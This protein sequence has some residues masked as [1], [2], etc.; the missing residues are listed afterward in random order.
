MEISKTRSDAWGEDLPEETR[1]EI[2]GFTKPPREGDDES[3]PHLKS[4]EDAREHA[5]ARGI[6]PPSR[7]G[8]YR[9]LARMRKAEHLRLVYRV[10]GAGETATDLAR[11]AGIS[12]ATAAE[13]FRALSVNAAMDGD[14]KGAALYANAAAK[15][16]EATLKSNEL[17]LRERAQATKDD[18]L[19]LAREKFEF[20]AA[21][22]AMA[23]AAEIKGIAADDGLDDDE[24]IQKVR[25]A[26]FGQ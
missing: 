11:E 2:Y 5:A 9:F 21:K 23:L 13:A 20:D 18:Q 10:Q 6:P 12:D 8:W 17:A 7:A 14:D 25:E 22:K 15:F 1:W 16:K 26:L 4:Y 19:R 24:K 3:R